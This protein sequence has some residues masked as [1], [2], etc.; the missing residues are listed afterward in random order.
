M[1]MVNTI[2]KLPILGYVI[3]LREVRVISPIN[4][5]RVAQRSKKF[6]SSFYIDFYGDPHNL[7]FEY[8]ADSESNSIERA[9]TDR[10]ALIAALNI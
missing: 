5:E 7:Y 4:T 1:S 8:V 3:N 9:T 6:R 2:V 10:A